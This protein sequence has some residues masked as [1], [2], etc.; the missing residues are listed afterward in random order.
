[1]VHFDLNTDSLTA[2]GFD[3]GILPPVSMIIPIY[4]EMIL[5]SEK[6]LRQGSEIGD[7]RNQPSGEKRLGER[8]KAPLGDGVN[9]NLAFIISQFREE[10]NFFADRKELKPAELYYRYMHDRLAEQVKVE[11]RLWA[12]LRTQSCAKT[13]IGALGY[14]KAL[15]KLLAAKGEAGKEVPADVIVAHQTFGNDQD[16]VDDLEVI[17]KEFHDYEISLVLDYHNKSKNKAK[18]F[19]E[20]YLKENRFEDQLE[21]LQY[22]RVKCKWDRTQGKIVAVDLIPRLSPLRVGSDDVFMSQGKASNQITR[23]SSRQV[24]ST[25][26]WTATWV[27]SWVSASRCRSSSA[28]SSHV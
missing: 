1:M 10:W 17:L 3:I 11:V 22:A 25:R 24:T 23:S 16:H 13:I 5:P 19:V 12:A 8:T 9:M 14:Q 15:K 6:M 21:T 4:E 18:K 27:S 26:R 28:S 7:A 2:E 20:A